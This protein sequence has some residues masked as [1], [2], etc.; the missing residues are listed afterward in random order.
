MSAVF[1]SPEDCVNDA[2]VRIGYKRRIGN[3][4]EGSAAAKVALD[5][6]SQTRD[7]MLRDGDW[8]FARRDISLTLLKSAPIGGYI[9]PTV[10][11]NIYPP[12]PWPYEYTY[13][14]D[15]LKI[16]NIITPPLFIPNYDPRSSNYVVANDTA[17]SPARKVILCNVGPAALMRYTGQVTDPSTWEPLFSEALS[18]ALARR[19]AP[20]LANLETEKA[21]AADEQVQTATAEMTQG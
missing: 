8:G 21:E 9:P 2:L 16:R 14:G 18:A 5:I 19:L 13:P 12:V 20:A 10:W 6:Y 7:A 17:Y 3:I 1:T 4:Y 15:C 11:S